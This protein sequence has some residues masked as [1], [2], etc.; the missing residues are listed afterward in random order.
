MMETQIKEYRKESMKLYKTLDK[1]LDN[2]LTLMINYMTEYKGTKETRT[3]MLDLYQALHPFMPLVNV[4]LKVDCPNH[5]FCIFLDDA[6]NAT[7]KAIDQKT[8]V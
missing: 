1:H 7:N 2:I 3:H 8:G 5:T 6:Y 4:H